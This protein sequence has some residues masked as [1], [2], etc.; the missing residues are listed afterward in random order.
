MPSVVCLQFPQHC[1]HDLNFIHDSI[2]NI[3]TKYYG[4]NCKWVSLCGPDL[5]AQLFYELPPL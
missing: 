5:R 4:R 3:E 1:I 2:N